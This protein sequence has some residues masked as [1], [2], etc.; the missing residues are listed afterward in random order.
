MAPLVRVELT[1]QNLGGSDP[2][3]VGEDIGAEDGTRTREINL[4]K[5][6]Q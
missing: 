1:F 6:V 3:S 2:K 4:G 5:V